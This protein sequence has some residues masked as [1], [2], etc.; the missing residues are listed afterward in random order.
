[1]MEKK[2]SRQTKTALALVVLAGGLFATAVLAEKGP[3]GM[4]DHD[5]MGGMGGMGAGRGAMLLQEFDTIDADKDGK[6]TAAEI[7]AHRLARFAAADTNSDGV[8]SA[9][10]L[11]AFQ[12]A[13]MAERMAEHTTRMLQWMDTD[14][15]GALSATEMPGGEAPGRLARLDTDGDGAISKAEAEAAGEGRMKKHRKGMMHD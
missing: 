2:M 10:E 14:G 5:G 11:S 15:D 7:E 13:Q 1:M 12:M 9:D 3:G 4:G 6:I 8:L